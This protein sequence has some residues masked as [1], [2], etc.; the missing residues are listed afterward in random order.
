MPAGR[1]TEYD[2]KYCELI[3]QFMGDPF[4]L[5]FRAACAKMGIP[6]STAYDWV[7]R[8][9]E[10]SDAVSQANEL[11]LLFYEEIGSQAMQ[12]GQEGFRDRIWKYMMANRHG[13]SENPKKEESKGNIT[14]N[15]VKHAD[16]TD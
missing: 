8:Y 1:P 15:Y 7:K 3:K 13:W 14:I 9:P 10:F 5:S 2:P 4:G 16:S 6:K 11:N 12:G